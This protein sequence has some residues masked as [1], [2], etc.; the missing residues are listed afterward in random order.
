MSVEIIAEGAQGYE[1][2]VHQ[3]K[4]ITQGAAH[5]GADAVKF[6]IIYADDLCTEKY[7][8][9]TL[10]KQ[11][12]MKEDDWQEVADEVRNLGLRF[13]VDIFGDNSFEIAKKIKADGI[14]IH[15]TD[16]YDDR[17]IRKAIEQFERIFISI[18]GIESKELK[19]WLDRYGLPGKRNIC[20]MYG[21]QA[22]PTPMENNNLLRIPKLK[23]VFPNLAF[24]FQDH[25]DGALPESL[26]I[27]LMVLPLGV[28]VIEKHI[29]LDRALKLE[30]Y[31]SALAPDQFREFVQKIRRFEQ[32]LGS[33]SLELT[34]EELAYRY[35]AMKRL[36]AAE[37][38]REGECLSRD[39]LALRRL[40]STDNPEKFIYSENEAV[41]KTV[42]RAVE[43]G[44]PILKE[45]LR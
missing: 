15:T 33:S 18:G 6:Q 41:D 10:F 20:I 38:V 21:Y 3:A 36:V 2:H 7:K 31:Q 42:C 4:L 5:A 35:K 34:P 25:T 22:E 40:D 19:E 12:E 39:K 13:Y 45:M 23:E 11:L 9:R 28:S 29:T 26:D 27:A 43:A 37:P 8:Y 24:G 14:K 17:L 1:G 16:F 30:D 44:E 32:A